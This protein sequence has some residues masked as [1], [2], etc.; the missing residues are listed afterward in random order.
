[1]KESAFDN[2]FPEITYFYFH[3]CGP[4]WYI[5]PHMVTNYEITYITKGEAEYTIDGTVYDL[6]AGDLLC[7]NNGDE[8]KAVATANNPMHHFS[9]NFY[10]K[11]PSSR[12]LKL[13]FPIIS[14]IGCRQDIIKL[15]KELAMYW[16][17]RYPGFIM[18]TR[19]L[20]MLILNRLEEILV[21][22]LEAAAGDAHVGRAVKTIAQR[23]Q[24]KLTVKGLAEQENLNEVYFG[25]L[26]KKETGM[27]VHQYITKIRVQN[28]E[29]MLQSGH[30]R[31]QEVAELCG[32]S[33][34]FHFYK[35]F[36]RYRGIPPSLYIP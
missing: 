15:F 35:S 9:V 5:L 23:Y 17:Q 29:N 4:E 16:S 1:M 6:V 21:Y 34:V 27:T 14:H 22:D 26:F 30:Y 8:K 11:R 24:E 33:D 20:L 10:S 13:P 18:K 3:K 36:R 7:L 12:N 32:F 28:A 2:F 25:S 31:V 19:A